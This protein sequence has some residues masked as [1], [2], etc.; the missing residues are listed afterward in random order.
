MECLYKNSKSPDVFSSRK[1]E[2]VAAHPQIMLLAWES[3]QPQNDFQRNGLEWGS[4][5]YKAWTFWNIP[6]T[7]L[8]I[9]HYIMQEWRTQLVFSSSFLLFSSL[10]ITPTQKSS[11]KQTWCC[12]LTEINSARN[13]SCPRQLSIL[14][15]PT[16]SLIGYMTMPQCL[17]ELA[18]EWNMMGSG[19][20]FL[21]FYDYW[22]CQWKD[23]N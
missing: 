9:L 12:P 5:K 13:E 18:E 17:K 2:L 22:S 1:T 6:M 20:R 7:V 10:L 23:N 21:D 3:V 4:N 16:Q 11:P 14:S 15:H 8:S 19:A